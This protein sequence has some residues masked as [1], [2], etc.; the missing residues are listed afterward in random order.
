M[1]ERRKFWTHSAAS[2]LCPLFKSEGQDELPTAYSEVP[3]SGSQTR[4]SDWHSCVP[5]QNSVW[6]KAITYLIGILALGNAIMFALLWN[7][8]PPSS[9]VHA[10]KNFIP[11]GEIWASHLFVPFPRSNADQALIGLVG[12][13]TVTF[14]EDRLFEE[15]P[16]QRSDEAW[17][18]VMPDGEGFIIVEDPKTFGLPPGMPSKH[19]PNRYGVAWTHQ[20]HCLVSLR[21]GRLL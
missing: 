18:S 5:K 16:S 10:V 21:S 4:D 12:Q 20:Y 8:V 3:E 9:T 13:E 14:K 17:N 7:L 2:A 19:G 15:A 1:K 11:E 6:N